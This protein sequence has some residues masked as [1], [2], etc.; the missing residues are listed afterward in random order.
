MH[1]P[2]FRRLLRTAFLLTLLS[3]TLAAQAA[4]TI[5]DIDNGDGTIDRVHIFQDTGTVTFTAPAGVT[6]VEYLVVGGGGSGGSGLNEGV[7][8]T[9]GGGAGGFRTGTLN[10]TSGDG[11]SV[12]VGAGGAVT[13]ADNI[14]GNSGAASV[15]GSVSAAGGGFGGGF[16]FVGGTGGSGGGGGGRASMAGG[17]GNTPAVTPSQGN[18]GGRAST[19]GT[20]GEA[21]GGGGGGAGATGANGGTTSG[22]A[23]GQGL[24]SRITNT[25]IWYAGGGGGAGSGTTAGSG[26]IGGGGGGA[27][28]NGANGSPGAP[29]TG[30]GGGGIMRNALGGEGGSGIVVVRYR[31]PGNVSANGASITIHYIP[32]VTTPDPVAIPVTLSG[33]GDATHVVAI[34]SLA[35]NG[36]TLS[37]TDTTGLTL[38]EGYGGF[39]K[40]QTLG[41]RGTLVDV[42]TALST[43]LRWNAP[44]REVRPALS[45][46]VTEYA[47]GTFYNPANDHYYKPVAETSKNWTVAKTDAATH[48]LFGMTGYLA[49]ITSR[50]ENEFVSDYTDLRNIWIAATDDVAQINAACEQTVYANQ[51]AAEGRWYWVAGPEACTQ[52]WRGA[53]AGS[54][55]A[56]RFALWYTGEPNNGSG[57]EH[58]AA[59]NYLFGGTTPVDGWN[60]FQNGTASANNY[61]VE[62]GGMGEASTARRATATA[63][64]NA[65]D[66]IVVGRNDA[67]T[68]VGDS[69]SAAVST[70]NIPVAAGLP[71][72][73]AA[74]GSDLI[75]VVNVPAGGGTLTINGTKGLTLSYGYTSFAGQTAIGFYGTQTAVATAL[76]GYLVWNAPDSA[77][78]VTLSVSVAEYSSGD[79]YNGVN[80]HYYRYVA[81]SNIDWHV[82][83]PAAEGLR[84]F[85]MTGYLATIT[86]AQENDFIANHTN[87]PN[88]WLGAADRDLRINEGCGESRY[89]YDG[90]AANA[91]EG[92][93]Y[94]VTGPEA[95]THFYQGRGDQGGSA[96]DG[97]FV[98]W[99]TGE[100]NNYNNGSPGEHHAVTNWNSTAG[101]WNDV[102]YDNTSVSGYLVEFGGLPGEASSALQAG[103]SGTLYAIT[104]PTSA[105]QNGI[106]EAGNAQAVVS[107]DSL[108]LAESGYSSIT[109]YTVTSSP[110]GLTCTAT[111][112]EATCTVSG[113]TNGTPYTFTVVAT[114][115]IGDSAASAASNSVTPQAAVTVNAPDPLPAGTSLTIIENADGSTTTTY[116]NT[117]GD[118]TNVTTWPDNASAGSITMDGTNGQTSTVLFDDGVT[119]TTIN[120]DGSI[121]SENVTNGVTT[122]VIVN[123]DGTIDYCQGASC[124]PGGNLPGGSTVRVDANG[125]LIVTEESVRPDASPDA[126]GT[127][128]TCYDQEFTS[129]VLTGWSVL[130]DQNFTPRIVDVGNGR[131]NRRLR[132]T[133]VGFDRLTGITKDIPIPTDGKMEL[134][135]IVHSYGGKGADGLAVVLS[136]WG[137]GSAPA[138][139]A[140]GGSLGYAQKTGVV[141]FENGWLGIGLNESGLFADA[142]E[143]RDGGSGS[144]GG[145]IV[146]RGSGSG[147]TGYTYLTSSG[148][149]LAPKIDNNY[150]GHR[151]L[152][153]FDATRSALGEIWITVSR[154]QGRNLSGDSYDVLVGPVNV[155]DPQYGQGP[156]PAQLRLSITGT[157]GSSADNYHELTLLQV[158]ADGCATVAAPVITTTGPFT[159]A[160]ERT[161]VATIEATSSETLSYYTSGG[162][163]E[164]LFQIDA[165]TGALNFIAAA[166]IGTYTVDVTAEDA[167]G[168]TTT[169][170]FT[171]NVAATVPDAPTAV[172]ATAGD[173][174]ASVSWAAPPFDG[175]SAIIGY[176]VT[177]VEDV[178]KTCTAKPPATSCT[179][180]GL[181]NGMAYTFTVTATNAVGTGDPSTASSAVMVQIFD[182]GTGA[183][184]DPYEIS[185]PE[186]FLRIDDDLAAHYALTGDIDLSG[187]QPWEPI[188]S[189]EEPFT[190]SLNGPDG[191]PATIT[192]LDGQPLFDVIGPGGEVSNL[193]IDDSVNSDAGSNAGL[194]ANEIIGTVDNPAIIDNITINAGSSIS[195]GD[196]IGGIAGTIENAE[197]SN[198]TID[199]NVSGDNN[200]GGIGGVI[201][202]TDIR[203]TTV[204]GDVSGNDNIGGIGGVISGG[205]ITD[206]AVT[207]EVTGT[208]DNVGGIGGSI[209]GTIITNVD[210][211]ARQQVAFSSTRQYGTAGEE[212]VLRAVLEKTPQQYPVRVRYAVQGIGAIGSSDPSL[213]ASGEFQFDEVHGRIRTLRLT[214]NTTVGEIVMTLHQGEEA[215]HARIGNPVSHT[216]VLREKAEVPLKASLAASQDG[217]AVTVALQGGGMVTLT[218]TPADGNDYTYDWSGSD[219]D[220]GIHTATGA[221]A[222]IELLPRDGS[223]RVRVLVT[224]RA[225]PYRS[226]TMEMALRIASSV[227]DAY[228]DFYGVAYDIQPHRLPIC[229][230]GVFRAETCSASATAVYLEVTEGYNVTLGR[231]SE[232]ASWSANE[233]GLGVETG[234]ILDENGLP[235]L[236]PDDQHY[237]HIGYLVDFEVHGLEYPGQSIPVV[238]PLPAGDTVPPAAVWRKYHPTLGWRNFTVNEANVLHSASRTTSGACPWPGSHLWGEP[239]LQVGDACVRLIIEDGGPNDQDERA[240]GSIRDP[241]TVAVPANVPKVIIS[242]GGGS[243]GPFGLFVLGL[244][245]LARHRF[246][247]GLI[248]LAAMAALLA[249]PVASGAEGGW[250]A[251]GQLGQARG[252]VDS[253]DVEA[254]LASLGVTTLEPSTVSGQNRTAGRLFGGYRFGSH[255]AVE[256]GYADLG[257]LE[258]RV[259]L[260]QE[261]PLDGI[262]GALPASGKGVELAMLGLLPLTGEL[263]LYGR[264]GLWRWKARYHVNALGETRNVHGGDAVVGLGVQYRLAEQWQLRGGLDHYRMDGQS[265]DLWGIG[266]IYRFR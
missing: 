93:W 135:F 6:E 23:G 96:V 61:L 151:Y 126:D 261:Q 166:V 181:T 224:E 81:A 43:N 222:D 204:N 178:T 124:T 147:T 84:L 46:S 19:S 20:T 44:M 221:A 24:S 62:F 157:T 169:A 119:T 206:S 78:Q 139:G 32:L 47:A 9:G 236:Y 175:G 3:L 70:T 241:G 191:Q 225:S 216:V 167:R 105:P 33:Y 265:V 58:Y 88:I 118:I 4:N 39:T 64:L 79:F 121:T 72:P 55:V 95:C 112:P 103:G 115:A 262:R 163:D 145:A 131:T 35:D 143:G 110:D 123:I 63:T 86:S 132:L 51:A 230:G 91:A 42:T 98:S 253:A 49:T 136:D 26:G 217:T 104:A 231:V 18:H 59:T 215:A 1:K 48:T 27:T 130:A 154:D 8:G 195:G 94:W 111:P 50:Q 159:V 28:A 102:A 15:F 254:G 199:G 192:G 160:P 162:A 264:A 2:L 30:G 186:Q 242:G 198:I 233:F 185:T 218:T 184:D 247:R 228:T 140:S 22:G 194:L 67:G 197:L 10:V 173:S 148:G 220:L 257:R 85:G 212:L 189:S 142:T 200:I 41:F 172:T 13:A 99:A 207:G 65:A 127:L 176:T 138:V 71:A 153:Q 21:G 188:G 56:G 73:F 137:A 243:I 89:P 45:V 76:K 205:T 109:L 246:R 114:N 203:N 211:I 108:T 57:L 87:A 168:N 239:G 38:E 252:E 263:E 122:K 235:A 54:L 146:L 29:N 75:A 226:A 69:V 196:N 234:D 116:T 34:V 7:K 52:F 244:L 170:T 210:V 180:G 174:A 179:V 125:V 150:P 31:V 238:V 213:L 193:I 133:D 214:P 80:G 36:G 202:D 97:R 245:L 83:R 152:V 260:A 256:G 259:Y 144:R 223:Y 14:S 201:N 128:G 68:V 66:Q 100:P 255:L 182:G 134:D 164:A 107:W 249:G 106:A 77:Q 177:A 208:G 248:A 183:V 240:D 141:G 158:R 37:L 250:Y 129:G 60:D 187:Q 117:D 17:S 156:L 90:T 266:A 11:Y 149:S 155:L 5:T 12:T 251:G 74:T 258:T 171:V 227:P 232:P 237:R 82:A 16:G 25:L 101:A 53:R 209:T 219:L 165:T 190:G 40:Q 229:P 113:L 120:A 92:R 161:A